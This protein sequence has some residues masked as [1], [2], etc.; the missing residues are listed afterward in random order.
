[1]AGKPMGKLEMVAAFKER[2]GTNGIQSDAMVAWFFETIADQVVSG[3]S[4]VIKG[5][6]AFHPRHVPSRRGAHPKTGVLFTSA[7]KTTLHFAPSTPLLERLRIA[8]GAPDP[9]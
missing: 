1:M 4:V 8:Q 2:F 5:F 7:P 6:G 9:C 3:S